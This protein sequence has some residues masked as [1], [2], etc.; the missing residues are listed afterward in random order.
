M[1]SGVSSSLPS[2]AVPYIFE[3]F[4]IDDE[5][6]SSLP[7]SVFLLGYVVGPLI[8]SPLSETIGRRPV[9]V[10]TFIVFFLF[11]LACALAPNWPSLLFF[12][13]VCG[14]MGASPQTVIGGVYADIFEARARGRVMAFYMAVRLHMSPLPIRFSQL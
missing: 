6:Q 5:S 4:K 3:N 1:N 14:C 10:Y 7:T 13:F 8:W 9:L 12:R 11:T 2:N